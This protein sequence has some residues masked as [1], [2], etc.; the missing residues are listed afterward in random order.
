MKMKNERKKDEKV[1]TSARKLLRYFYEKYRKNN[2]D[3]HMSKKSSKFAA[4][5]DNT[6]KL[7]QLFY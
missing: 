3:L 2:I 6:S 1:V 7:K 5:F 4:D